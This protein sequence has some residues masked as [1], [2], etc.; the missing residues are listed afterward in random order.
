MERAPEM[1]GR[2]KPCADIQAGK[3]RRTHG[4]NNS[5]SRLHVT[6]ANMKRR[7][8]NPTE[9]EKRNYGEKV[10]LCKEWHYF[11]PF[12]IWAELNGYDEKATIDRIDGSKGYF[13]EN[14]RFVD[15][16]VQAANRKM[17]DK[18]KSGFIGVSWDRGKWV[19]RV[20]WHRKQHGM[21]RFSDKVAAAIARDRFIVKNNLPH[22]LNFTVGE[23]NSYL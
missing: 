19:A 10:T 2:C 22:T 11:K 6:W 18:N 21:G 20:Q 13:P 17:T 23:L 14:C 1:S 5:N 3:K 9:K 15:Y 12:M 8:L 16:S 7:C 4:F